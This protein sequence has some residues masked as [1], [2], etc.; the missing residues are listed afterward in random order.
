VRCV[1]ARPPQDQDHYA[2]L[3]LSRLRYKATDEDFK[4]ACAWPMHLQWPPRAPRPLL[5]VMDERGCAGRAC[6][7]GAD[8]R[9]VLKHHPD[10]N[11]AS[12]GGRTDQDSF[13]KCIQK[14]TA[15]CPP[16]PVRAAEAARLMEASWRGRGWG[17]QQHTTS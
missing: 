13:F 14:G 5:T 4:R 17:V 10:K 15:R 11:A 1:R 9:K 6:V 7:R 16:S 12:H 2:V 8:R 3:G